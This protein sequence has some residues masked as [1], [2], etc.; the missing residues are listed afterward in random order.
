MEGRSRSINTVVEGGEKINGGII[1]VKEGVKGE[2]EIYE[3]CRAL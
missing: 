1:G 3:R 2:Y